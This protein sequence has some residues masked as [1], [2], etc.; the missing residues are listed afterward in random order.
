MGLTRL[1]VAGDGLAES[2]EDGR[3]L[4]LAS[5][6]QEADEADLAE[7]PVERVHRVGEAVGVEQ[8][9][10]ARSQDGGPRLGLAGE[11]DPQEARLR[12]EQAGPLGSRD[13]R[14]RVADPGVVER[15]RRLVDPQVEGRAEE[16]L[17]EELLDP[18]V[19]PRQDRPRRGVGGDQG[20][21]RVLTIPDSSAELTP[22]PEMSATRMPSRFPPSSRTMS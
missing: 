3:R 11:A 8:E 18:G 14:R 21:A 20:A 10:L 1:D 17:G 4:V 7:R 15:A 5:S 13:D 12:F 2:V 6:F 16:P 19:E 9:R 22:C